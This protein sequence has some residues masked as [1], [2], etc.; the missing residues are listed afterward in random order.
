MKNA[1][2]FFFKKKR[3]GGWDLR[4]LVDW[5]ERPRREEEDKALEAFCDHNL[6]S[7]KKDLKKFP[8]PWK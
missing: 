4:S 8:D 5:L 1:F 3:G 2:F 6:I 7:L